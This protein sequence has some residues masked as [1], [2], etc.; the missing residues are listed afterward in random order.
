M[1]KR[2][3]ALFAAVFLLSACSGGVSDGAA[4]I[5]EQPVAAPTFPALPTGLVATVPVGDR[6]EL[7]VYSAA[8]GHTLRSIS[9]PAPDDKLSFSSDFGYAAQSDGSQIHFYAR[10]GDSFRSVGDCGFRRSGSR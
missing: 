6:S 8:D 1:G 7:R 10:R 9:L 4:P 5:W 2:A 3:A